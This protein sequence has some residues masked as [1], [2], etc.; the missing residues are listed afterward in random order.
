MDVS[1]SPPLQVCSALWR[2]QH[3]D[4][5]M[6]LLV[7]LNLQMGSREL[8]TCLLRWLSSL[9]SSEPQ[10]IEWSTHIYDALSTSHCLNL[11]ISSTPMARILFSL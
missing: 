5:S 8:C 7:I 3:D 2:A 9:F 6:R 4:R 1:F 11:D 10:A